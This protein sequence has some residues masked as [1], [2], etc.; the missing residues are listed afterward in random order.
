MKQS[1]VLISFILLIILLFS[2][3]NR[4]NGYSQLKSL[5]LDQ[6]PLGM[7]PEIFAPGLVSTSLSENTIWFCYGGYGSWR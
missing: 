7:I 6:T 1:V 2:N 4:Q 3:C 5:Y